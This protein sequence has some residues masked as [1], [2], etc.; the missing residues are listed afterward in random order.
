MKNEMVKSLKEILISIGFITE[1]QEDEKALREV[2]EN[3]KDKT[4]LK[5]GL[6]MMLRSLRIYGNDKTKEEQLK[7]A[8]DIILKY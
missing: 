7:N 5:E 3:Q 6:V 1:T 2:L 8:I 4:E